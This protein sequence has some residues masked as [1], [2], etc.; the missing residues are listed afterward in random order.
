MFLGSEILQ[1]GQAV[2]YFGGFPIIS[3]FDGICMYLLG[4]QGHHSS[5]L[6]LPAEASCGVTPGEGEP[7]CCCARI[8]ERT[9]IQAA[10][11]GLGSDRRTVTALLGNTHQVIALSGPWV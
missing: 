7:Q 10:R 4:Y 2:S 1:N 5:V 3:G 8:P 6:S 9:L 11:R